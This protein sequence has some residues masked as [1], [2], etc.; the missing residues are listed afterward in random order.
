MG[1]GGYVS[2]VS[3]GIGI[4]I[5]VSVDRGIGGCIGGFGTEGI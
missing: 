4:G 5:E 2:V 1:I 3:V